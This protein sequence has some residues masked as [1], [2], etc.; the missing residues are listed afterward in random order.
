MTSL[1]HPWHQRGF[2]VLIIA[3]GKARHTEDVHETKEE[4]AARL[5]EI[6]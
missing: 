1:C 6:L 2:S 5:P 3:E 4:A